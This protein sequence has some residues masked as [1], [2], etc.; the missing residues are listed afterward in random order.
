MDLHRIAMT[1]I[2]NGLVQSSLEGSG[3]FIDNYPA[4][5]ASPF[6]FGPLGFPEP[7]PFLKFR[8]LLPFP[9]PDFGLLPLGGRP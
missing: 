1:L 9:E 2:Y 8:F 7:E 3:S 5:G 6:G 4:C